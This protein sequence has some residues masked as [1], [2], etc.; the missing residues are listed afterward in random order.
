MSNALSYELHKLTSRLDRVADGLLRRDAGMSYSRFLTL[1]A[2]NET[3]G[4]QRDLAQWLGQSEPSTS[5]MVGLLAEDGLVSV[6]RVAGVGNRRQ[7]E[8]TPKGARL[9]ER[10]ASLLEDRFVDIVQRS[11]V[12][13][14]AY[15]RYTRRLLAQL[16]ADQRATP[17][18]V[19]T[20]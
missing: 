15:Q 3:G 7:L 14:G 1:F 8:L 6:T 10:C 4:S 2:V 13:F 12:P 11:G 9:V 16:E 18:P 5:R 17:E 19:A 20:A